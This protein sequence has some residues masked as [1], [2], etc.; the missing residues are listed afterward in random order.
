MNIIRMNASVQSNIRIPVDSDDTLLDFYIPDNTLETTDCQKFRHIIS[1]LQQNAFTEEVLFN[2]VNQH[3]GNKLSYSMWNNVNDAFAFY[4]D[5]E[6][7]INGDV[8]KDNM[9]MSIRRQLIEKSIFIPNEVLQEIVSTICN[10]IVEIPGVI[11][12]N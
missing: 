8:Y 9:Y 12:K 6:L 10:F 7:G 3:I 1:P 5:E 2:V 4:W 11:I